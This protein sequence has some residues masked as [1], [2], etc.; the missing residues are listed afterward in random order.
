MLDIGIVQ[1]IVLLLLS[2]VKIL[3]TP[4]GMITGG[5][6]YWTTIIITS[7]GGVMGALVFFF[8]GRQIVKW[9]K[10]KKPKKAFTGQN[11][12]IVRTKN[13][14][15][16]IGMAATM[17]IISVPLSAILVAK[18]FG[19]DKK[20]STVLSVSAIA[21]SFAVTTISYLVYDVFN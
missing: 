14:F 17:G 13:R 11:R 20:A 1:A 9:F 7:S 8:L 16:L 5:Y 19:D 4:I 6:S 18:Y 12:W 3:F 15:G 10:S 21:W 2:G